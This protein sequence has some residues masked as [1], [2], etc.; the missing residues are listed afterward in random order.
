MQW[1]PAAVAD[2]IL[3]RNCEYFPRPQAAG[4]IALHEQCSLVLL[5]CFPTAVPVSPLQAAT[6]HQNQGQHTHSAMASR[7]EQPHRYSPAAADIHNGGRPQAHH[8]RLSCITAQYIVDDY[9][10][11]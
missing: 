9:L 2:S 1:K 4:S 11:R 3:F 5:S 10:E 7:L 6:P 8:Q